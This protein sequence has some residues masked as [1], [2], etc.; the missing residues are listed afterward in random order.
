MPEA[1]G[2][3]R[4]RWVVCDASDIGDGVECLACGQGGRG[5]AESGQNAGQRGTAEGDG[6]AV[7]EGIT[8]TGGEHTP[9]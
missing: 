7:A 5:E 9:A 3:D 2:T 8:G 1:S 4:G 6:K